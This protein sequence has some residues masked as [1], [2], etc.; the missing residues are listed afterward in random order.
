MPYALRLCALPCAQAKTFLTI[1]HLRAVLVCYGRMQ[2]QE[3]PVRGTAKF[4]FQSSIETKNTSRVY[5]ACG[6]QFCGRRK[7]GKWAVEG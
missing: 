1:K 3:L 6:I 4:A 7:Q 2:R 5:L